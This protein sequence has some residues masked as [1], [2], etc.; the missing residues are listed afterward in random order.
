MGRQGC[1]AGVGVVGGGLGSLGA[2]GSAFSCRG[3]AR[4]CYRACCLGSVGFGAVG[5]SGAGQRG[6]FATFRAVLALVRAAVSRRYGAAYDGQA[7]LSGV[8]CRGAY[9][10]VGGFGGSGRVGVLGRVAV[11]GCCSGLACCEASG[12]GRD[13]AGVGATSCRV[14]N[15]AVDGGLAFVG[16]ADGVGCGR[17]TFSVFVF[18]AYAG[19]GS[20]SDGGFDR[21]EVARCGARVGYRAVGVGRVDVSVGLLVAWG[22]VAWVV[23]GSVG[24]GGGVDG[25]GGRVVEVAGVGGVVV[26]WVACVGGSG[27]A[28]L[29]GWGFGCSVG[30]WSTGGV[31]AG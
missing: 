23:D 20:G 18:S 24:V 31:V 16:G 1:V 15:V 13:A 8:G 25:V 10:L 29:V 12:G 4:R 19:G 17:R 14:V 27:V 6:S 28:C 11:A 26:G 2:A 3:V 22:L 21:F 30:L 9:R 7:D 5:G